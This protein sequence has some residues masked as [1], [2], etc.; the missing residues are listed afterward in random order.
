MWLYDNW[1]LRN[2]KATNTLRLKLMIL[3]SSFVIVI[4]C[5][6]WIAGVRSAAQRGQKIDALLSTV[7]FQTYGAVIGIKD[8]Y[9][10]DGGSAAW[11]CTDNSNSV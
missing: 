6:I 7:F 9:A 5:F 1:S 3:W 4:G 2:E 11:S 10:A 8:I